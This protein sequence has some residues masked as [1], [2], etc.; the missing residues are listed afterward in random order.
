MSVP[1][2]LM[3]LIGMANTLGDVVANS[4]TE[5]LIH[6]KAAAYD[7]LMAEIEAFLKRELEDYE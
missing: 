1:M 5:E 6:T 2:N 7:V 4:S 3:P